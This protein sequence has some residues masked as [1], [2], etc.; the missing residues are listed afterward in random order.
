MVK[1]LE[2]AN[3]HQVAVRHTAQQLKQFFL[4]NAEPLVQQ[5]I[6]A[7]LGTG[8]LKSTN[9]EAR[10]EVWEVLKTLMLQS[11]DKLDIE[12]K[13]AQDVLDAVSTGK[14]TFE[15]GEKLLKLYKQMKDIDT[16]GMLPGSSGSGGLHITINSSS[17]TTPIEVK[18]VIE[19]DNT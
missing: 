6:D 10:E 15:E 13:T 14:C 9:A 4:D 16:Q 8:K 1:L 12:V 3:V 18:E 7:A 5:Y 19:H 2:A 17:P 11:S